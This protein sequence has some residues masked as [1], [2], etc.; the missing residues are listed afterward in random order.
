M[1]GMLGMLVF[2]FISDIEGMGLIKG[3]PVAGLE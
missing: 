2:F 1:Y 3:K